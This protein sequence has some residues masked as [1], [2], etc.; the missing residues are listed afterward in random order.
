MAKT[1]PRLPKVDQRS[2]VSAREAK[3]RNPSGE[4]ERPPLRLHFAS[5]LVALL[6][7]W[8][9]RQ[10]RTNH[11]TG[12][13]EELLILR[14][15][16][17]PYS[18]SWVIDKSNYDSDVLPYPGD[19]SMY[20]DNAIAARD[21]ALEH[22]GEEMP[23]RGPAVEIMPEKNP[24]GL[25][26]K[27]ERMYGGIKKGYEAKGD[28]RAKEIAARTVLAH[29]KTT[30]GLKNPA[31]PAPRPFR[32]QKI[33]A[34]IQK[35]TRPTFK[36][37]MANSPQQVA[38]GLA[39]YIGDRATEYFVVLFVNI[40]N[41]IIGYTELTSLNTGSV[42]VTTSGIFREALLA[43]AVAII[44]AHQHPSGNAIPSDDDIVLW[45]RLDDAGRLMGIPVLDHLVIGQSRFY[46]R[47]E[48]REGGLAAK[49]TI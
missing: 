46:S 14:G 49:G 33:V 4:D 26:A 23:E 41:Q 29:A 3:R 35:D 2:L 32:P 9:H 37:P 39:D 27:G 10:Q 15:I 5:G 43:G 30:P 20:V 24:A 34:T 25:T 17:D 42:E 12:I 16:G 13:T 11:F 48:G 40:K 19:G 6:K 28:P 47:S 18:T 22:E 38:E 7:P 8:V 21:W 44:T 45:K 36:N 1:G 31:N